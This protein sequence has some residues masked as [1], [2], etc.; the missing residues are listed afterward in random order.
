MKPSEKCSMRSNLGRALGNKSPQGR[1]FDLFEYQP[2]G[3]DL[4][5]IGHRKS[6]ASSVSHHRRLAAGMA[7]F[8]EAAEDRTVAQIDDL[9]GP[10]CSE[11]RFLLHGAA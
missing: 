9:G 8:L 11:Q 1:A 2:I 6:L 3:P 7:T 4:Q 10:P 5:H